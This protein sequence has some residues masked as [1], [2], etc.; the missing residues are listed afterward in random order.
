MC[1]DAPSYFF[2]GLAFP[3]LCCSVG[4]EI[5]PHRMALAHELVGQIAFTE[6]K[7]MGNKA[8]LILYS[9]D[10]RVSPVLHTRCMT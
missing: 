5:P 10:V 8:L 2:D 4:L 6:H 3:G 7:Q 1:N 9:V